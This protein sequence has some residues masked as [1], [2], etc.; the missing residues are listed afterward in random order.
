MIKLFKDDFLTTEARPLAETVV[1]RMVKFERKKKVRRVFD[2]KWRLYAF[3]VEFFTTCN[4][5]II[6]CAEH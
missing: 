3:F 4:T 6:I 1:R 5:E 2:L